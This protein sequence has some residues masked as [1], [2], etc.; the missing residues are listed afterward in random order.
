MSSRR[1]LIA[2]LGA[3][4]LAPLLLFAQQRVTKVVLLGV[5]QPGA[6]PQPL[7]EAIK[8]GLR[9]LGY[10]EGRN[11]A[12]LVRWAEGRTDK[13]DE[14]AGDMVRANVDLITTLSTPAAL[15]ARRATSSIPIVF[16]GV[17]DPVGTGVVQSLAHPGGN[18]TGFATLEPELSAKRL[19]LLH[20]LVPN[21]TRIA[22]LWNDTNPSMKTGARYAQ[23]AGKSLGLTVQSLG[24][25]DLV[26]FDASFAAIRG[27]DSAALL[28]LADPF[29]RANRQRIVDFAARS[30][31]PAIYETREFVEAGGLISYGPNLLAMQRRSATYIDRILNGA[32]PG[33]L[34][35]E[36]PTAFELIINM[37]TANALGIKLSDSILARADEVIQ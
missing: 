9:D 35:V 12:F 3:S 26:D 37:K 28:T 6:P 31:L 7:M 14:G 29:T 24:V 22:M 23:E 32:K 5:L 30:R 4:T 25:H 36:Q 33:D 21:M 17:G 13:L 19:D 2:G 16:T 34:P 11:I 1:R 15:A 20:Q 10:V 27:G 18:A 8:E